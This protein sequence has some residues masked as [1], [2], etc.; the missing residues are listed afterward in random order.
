[1]CDYYSG[2]CQVCG[3]SRFHVKIYCKCAANKKPITPCGVEFS[4]CFPQIDPEWVCSN[5]R[6]KLDD[7]AK[8]K[9]GEEKEDTRKKLEGQQRM[10]KIKERMDLRTV[11][12]E[13]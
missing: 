3:Q 4:V 5:C 9:L 6:H 1:M 8:K 11:I 10:K 12:N 2:H 7:D 13:S